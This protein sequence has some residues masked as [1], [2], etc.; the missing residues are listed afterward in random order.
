M[1]PSHSSTENQMV[2]YY[3]PLSDSLYNQLLRHDI[4]LT[5]FK[6]D[7][8][9]ENLPTKQR[10]PLMNAKR[11]RI[12]QLKEQ[13]SPLDQKFDSCP[14][15]LSLFFWDRITTDKEFKLLHR[16]VSNAGECL[17]IYEYENGLYKIFRVRLKR[18]VEPKM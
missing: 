7:S 10:A 8:I 1:I 9:I 16:L 4:L 11:E 13:Y 17:I 12:M 3:S 2:F 14:S 15:E 18:F 6:T 5:L